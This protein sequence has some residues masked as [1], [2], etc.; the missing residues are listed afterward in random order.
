MNKCF[1][2]QPFDGGVY[3]KRFDDIYKPAIEAAGLESYRV[4]RDPKVSIP[5][6]DIEKGIKNSDICFAE[7]STD[8]PN[9]WFE[10][11]FAFAI[12]KNVV[13]VC[14]EKR[15]SKYPF[16][17]QHRTVLEYKA[18][19]TSDFNELKDK[20]TERIR[21]LLKKDADIIKTTQLSPVAA[22]E[23]LSQHEMVA[24]ISIMQNS[25]TVE[26]AVSTYTVK[27]DM[28]N[29]GFTDIAVSLALKLLSQKGFIKSSRVQDDNGNY[30]FAYFM[31]EIGV[32]WL[33][34]NQEKLVLRKEIDK[35]I[36]NDD[37]GDLPF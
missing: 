26:D 18:E 32:E 15:T 7:I 1:C 11:G 20:I 13:M 14:S 10:L 3:D 31:E 5:I 16:D 33:L 9:V 37:G 21:A 17:I 35:S 34:K 8:N 22:V 30:F 4:D 25:L 24:L 36:Q 6:E 2:I 27:S 12:P 28:N 29:V 23:G 19:S